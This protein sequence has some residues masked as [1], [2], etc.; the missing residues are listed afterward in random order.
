MSIAAGAAGALFLADAALL[1]AQEKDVKKTWKVGIT[2]WDIRVAGRPDSFA[3]AKELGFEGVQ[4]SY[5]PEGPDSL[6]TRANRPKFL[7]AAKEAGVA[8]SSLCIGLFNGRPL[9]TTPEAE[10]WVEDCL[11]AMEEM[12]VPQVLIPFFGNADLDTNENRHLL[13]VVIEKFKRL[14]PIAERKKKI[15]AIE[16]TLSAEAHIGLISAIGSDAIKVY[17]DTLNTK[18]KGFDIYHEIELLGSLKLISEIHFKEGGAR[19]GDGT[20]D[21]TRVRALL[22]KH[23]FEGWIVVEGSVS[24]DLKESHAANSQFIKKLIGR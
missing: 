13:P 9:A 17:Y 12:D 16:S 6:A 18:N 14:A 11:N 20:I 4:V 2:D 23:S 3:I 7:A 21:F 22:E 19:L 15:L 24:G 10:G 5:Q 1:E 8:I